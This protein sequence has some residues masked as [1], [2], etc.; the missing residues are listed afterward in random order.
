MPPA[1]VRDTQGF[2]GGWQCGLGGK[3]GLESGH[4]DQSP[5]R[6]LGLGLL[7][8]KMGVRV[9]PTHGVMVRMG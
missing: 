4:L 7:F 1:H 5:R 8:C 2:V 3:A 6:G 9:G